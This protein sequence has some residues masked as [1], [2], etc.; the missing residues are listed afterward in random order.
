MT[1]N[2]YIAPLQ[3]KL[4][5]YEGTAQETRKNKDPVTMPEQQR[6]SLRMV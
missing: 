1:S 4:K 2:R 5:P 6:P 3:Q